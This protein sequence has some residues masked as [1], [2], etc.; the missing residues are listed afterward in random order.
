MACTALN[1][2]RNILNGRNFEYFSEDPF[3][4]GMMASAITRGVQ[5]HPNR[6]TTIKHFA[7]NGQEWN[8]F[9]SNSIV[10]ER[11]LREIYLKGFKI[12]IDNSLPHSL[13]TSYNLINGV[14]SSERRDLVVDVIRSEWE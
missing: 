7:C 11:A 9:N 3:I 6:G 4:S 2:H 12:A 10:S 14:H 5:M 13:M 1:I 8:R